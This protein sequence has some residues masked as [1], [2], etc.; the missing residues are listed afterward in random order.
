MAASS[1]PLLGE[2]EALYASRFDHFVRVGDVEFF[3]FN[4]VIAQD[5]LSLAFLYQ[6]EIDHECIDWFCTSFADSNDGSFLGLNE[7]EIV[8]FREPFLI[9]YIVLLV[10]ELGW[11]RSF[12]LFPFLFIKDAILRL[13]CS[14]KFF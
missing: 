12:L 10:P 14:S 6:F 7:H 4:F 13:S 5:S 9:L 2:I 3:S 8:F 11:L 1:E